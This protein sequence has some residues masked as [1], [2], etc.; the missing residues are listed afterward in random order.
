MK[1]RVRQVRLSGRR[2]PASCGGMGKRLAIKTRQARPDTP[3]EN[4]GG[5]GGP[6]HCFAV[7][8]QEQVQGDVQ[9]RGDG[10]KIHGRLVSPRARITAASRL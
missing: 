6:G 10:Q 1:Q 5:Q 9:H 3:E 2:P 4:D 8:D 7:Q